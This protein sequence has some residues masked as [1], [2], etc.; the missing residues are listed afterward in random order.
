MAE[1]LQAGDT[2][3]EVSLDLVSGDTVTLPGDLDMPYGVVLFYRGH[4]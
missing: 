2:F 1:K 4:W 3:P